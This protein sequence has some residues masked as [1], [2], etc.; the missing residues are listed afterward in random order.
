MGGLMTFLRHPAVRRT[1]Q[2]AAG[3]ILVAAS[4][5]KIGDLDAFAGSVHNFHM[6]PI[7]PIASV[8]LIAVTIPWVELVAGL[9]LVLGLKPR[10]AAVV[11]TVLL[12]VFT[13]AVLQAMARGLSFDCGC[14]GKSGAA[15][16]GARKLVENVGMLAIGVVAA[17][18]RR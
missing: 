10:A 12:G 8:N 2:L 9:A 1:C 14:F 17:F 3:A 4:L 5:P 16:I 11:Y 15:T 6:E 18:E 7:V 13:V